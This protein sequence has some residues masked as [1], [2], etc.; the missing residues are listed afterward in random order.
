[1]YKAVIPARY[2]STR[3]PGKPLQDIAGKPMVVRVAEQ[4]AKSQADE[5]I[6]ATDHPDIVKAC[7]AHNIQTVMTRSDWPTGTDRIAEV[8]KNKGWSANTVVVNVQGDEPL[9]NPALI[10]M[11]AQALLVG[12]QDIATC[13]HPIY[14]WEEFK[15]PNVEKIAMQDNGEAL[16]FSRSPI[17]YPRDHF[18]QETWSEH[19]AGQTLGTRHIG[20]YAYKTG[21]LHTYQT[22]APAQI[23][24]LESLEQ[25]RALAHGFRIKVCIIQD[26]PLPGVDTQQDLDQVR[27]LFTARQAC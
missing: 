27:L 16:Y 26:A 10:D 4:A 17:P 20:L 25:L 5:V 2:A 7:Q 11:V 3:L 8:A 13:G 24:Q 1:M 22:L 9:I 18:V 15:N 12:H 23:E 21:F 6:V 19:H 14:S